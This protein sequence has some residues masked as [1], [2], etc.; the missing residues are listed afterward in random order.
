PGCGG[1]D[2]DDDEIID[3]PMPEGLPSLAELTEGWNEIKPGGDTICADGSEYS[4]FV[5]PGT[6][7]QLLIEFSGGGA[8]WDATTCSMPAMFY[9]DSLTGVREYLVDAP[10][11]LAGFVGYQS[12]DNPFRDWTHVYVPY[13]TGDIHW[14]NSVTTYVEGSS[15]EITV[16]HRGA[17]NVRAILDWLRDDSELTASDVTVTGCSAGSYGSILWTPA[18]AELYST[19]RVT[20]HGDAGI[21]IVTESW[22][23]D[24]FAAW[25]S[26]GAFP[27]QIP[28]LDPSQVDITTLSLTDI[29]IAIADYYSEIPLSQYTAEVDGVQQLFYLA[30]GGSVDEWS[31]QMKTSLSD[32][33]AAVDN[34]HSYIAPG[35]TH[36]IIPSDDAF[37]LQVDG[38]SYIDWLQN[39]INR[40]PV[41]SVT[42][43]ECSE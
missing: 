7:D 10:E 1:D 43:I 36:C 13:C 6:T 32:I 4:F 3:D 21:G 27:A 20:Q 38:I 23:L 26:A 22:I 24:S 31:S 41:D 17:V 34:F 12:E 28:A 42:C 40:E 29:Y 19:A 9:T 18:V 37:S 35:A 15:D 11:A 25:D 5:R 14:G 33:E 39:Q 8:C 2:D 30:M 16:N